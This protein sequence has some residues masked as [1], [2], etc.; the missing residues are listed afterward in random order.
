MSAARWITEA[1]VEGLLTQEEALVALEAGLARLATD[2]AVTIPKAVHA[3]GGGSVHSLGAFDA[4]TGLAGFKNWVN[5]PRGAVALMTLFDIEQGSVRAVIE[6]GTLGSLRTSGVTA[7]AT[8]E[9]ADPAADDLAILGS[10]RQ[11]LLQLGAVALVRPPKRVRFWSPTGERRE[12]AAA[13]ARD[14]YGVNAVAAD[15]LEAAL[16]GASI[17]T[18]VTRAKEPFLSLDLLAHGAHLNAVGAVLPGF[19]EVFTPV[20]TGADLVVGDSVAAVSAL[21]EMKEALVADPSLAGRT[22]SLTALLARRASGGGSRPPGSRLTVF[23][24]VGIGASDLAVAAEVLRRAE[25]RDVGRHLDPI[26][27]RPARWR[28]GS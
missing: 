12:A 25:A 27:P 17:V 20:L 14:R 15:T 5:T 26:T 16:A 2:E 24:S 7:L 3:W 28:R 11:A 6:A 9:L 23:K 19:A 1:N 18:S 21:R 4:V 13:S 8:R 22:R 10:G